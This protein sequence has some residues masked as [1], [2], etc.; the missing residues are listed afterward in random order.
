MSSQWR[1][2]LVAATL[3]ALTSVLAT[4][5]AVAQRA[6]LTTAGPA[7]VTFE[8]ERRAVF[9]AVVSSI[10]Q[11]FL[12]TE[13][14]GHI[15]FRKLADAAWPDIANAPS[16]ADA[17]ARINRLLAR[18]ETSHTR[19]FTPDEPEYTILSD[20]FS[21]PASPDTW[22]A[23]PLMASGGFF[24]A[25]IDGRDHV[26]AVLEGSPAIAADILVGDEIVSIDG[27]PYHPVRSLRGRAGSSVD[28]NIRR[29]KDGPVEIRRVRIVTLQPSKAFDAAMQSSARVIERNGKR[30]GYIHVWHM[31]TPEAMSQALARIDGSRATYRT[32][33]GG[34]AAH[35][36]SDGSLVSLPLDALIVDNRVKIGG[37]SSVVE[38]FLETLLG[39]RGGFTQQT[40]RA[41]RRRPT[42][43]ARSFKGRSVMLIDGGTRSAAE[44]FAQGYK[45]E[46]LGPLFGTRTAGAVSGA[47]IKHLPGG[48]ILYV[49]VQRVTIN[50]ISLEGV[51]VEPTREIARPIPYSAGAEP[52]LEAAIAHLVGN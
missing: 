46:D 43:A 7:A 32:S 37:R 44:L 5:T 41:P 30:L 16:M 48:L 49:A 18:L 28:I 22:A 40:G 17:V 34:I 10:E 15:E 27:A 35:I 24:T 6:D 12:D 3:F 33:E 29:T 38:R 52:V 21:P 50:G 36:T 42:H 14:L 9:D 25:R 1:T 47:Q 13:K 4:A 51:G 26:T 31:I 2:N 11:S 19:V 39:P 23:P 20:V 45:N 8:P